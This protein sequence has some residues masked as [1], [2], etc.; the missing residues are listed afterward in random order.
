MSP[1]VHPHR[2][3]SG[4]VAGRWDLLFFRRVSLML[5]AIPTEWEKRYFPLLSLELC[6]R[7]SKLIPLEPAAFTR[8]LVP[9]LRKSRTIHSSS[10][11]W[12]E[13]T[14]M[15]I[16][17]IFLRKAL[18]FT[19]SS[20]IIRYVTCPIVSSIFMVCPP[21]I[22]AVLSSCLSPSIWFSFPHRDSLIQIQV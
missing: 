18:T 1:S 3:T 21:L 14:L 17:E 16:Y 13:C 15:H 5:D 10:R 7:R 12:H 2:L 4:G 22:S 6:W 8:H 9:A 11:S 19:G 20:L